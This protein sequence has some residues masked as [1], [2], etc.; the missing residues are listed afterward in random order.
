MN[1]ELQKSS[2]IALRDLL[3]LQKEETLLVIS[4]EI[5]KE[6]GYS[7]FEVGK[8]LCKEAVYVEMKSREMN[9]EEP[10]EQIAELM[11]KFDVVVCPTAKSLTHTN[12]RREAV[13]AGARVATMPGISKSTMIRCL[14]ADSKKVVELTNSVK[15]ALENSKVIRVISKNG[16]DVEMNI[17]GRKII[18]STGVLRNKGESGNLPSGEVYLAPVEGSTN[19]VIVFDGSM[20]GIG[21]L[22]NPIKVTV[23]DGYA[24]KIIGKTEAKKFQKMLDKVGKDARAVGEFGIGTNYKAKIIGQILEDE[25]VLGT[26][27]IAFGNNISMGGNI[28][29]PI[30]LDGLVKKPTVLVD[31]IVI[32][33]SGV[34]LL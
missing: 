32:M 10:P 8:K 9:G 28:N 5:E 23:K 24:E 11:K 34:L 33:E 30:H 21:I 17:E 3:G 22:K 6:I 18:P 15:N 7:L 4:D 13:K 25:K 14:S 27:H 1:K 16:T 31:D 2:L 29:V 20:A 19:G 12:A 26:I